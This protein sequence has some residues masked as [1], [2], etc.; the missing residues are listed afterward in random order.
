[1]IH[2]TNNYFYQIIVQTSSRCRSCLLN[3]TCHCSV[4]VVGH[5]ELASREKLNWSEEFQFCEQRSIDETWPLQ[6]GQAPQRGMQ[7]SES[8]S[9]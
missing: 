1:M 5:E 8:C 3:L 9:L 2:C 6:V 7:S 4:S